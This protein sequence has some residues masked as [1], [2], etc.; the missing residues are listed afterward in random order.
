MS[1]SANVFNILHSKLLITL[2]LAHHNILRLLC[3]HD[4]PAWTLRNL[5]I[6]EFKGKR[7][8]KRK[9]LAFHNR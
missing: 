9:L 5:N 2:Q 3:E 7:H 8:H 6:P 4:Q 1:N